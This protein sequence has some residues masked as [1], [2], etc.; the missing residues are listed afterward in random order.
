V[1]AT[2]S[3]IYLTV[4]LEFGLG[5]AGNDIKSLEESISAEGN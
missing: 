3:G 2:T 4:L 5:I 1:C